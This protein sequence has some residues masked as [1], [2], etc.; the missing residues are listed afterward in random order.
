MRAGFTAGS[1]RARAATVLAALA[2]A[3]AAA[4]S[5][6]MRYHGYAPSDADLAAIRIGTDTRQTVAERLGRPSMVGVLEGSDWFWVQSDWRHE[7]WRAPVETD[8]QVVAISFDNR[9]RV[10]N[11]QR[12]GLRDGEV[13]ALS[14]RVTDAGSRPRVLTQVF[15]VFG[16][17]SPAMAGMAN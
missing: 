13:V 2:L 15:R 12:F 1:I 17:F 14:A 6:Q 3:L 11:I 4:C 8:R 9:D 7:H 16:Q 5:P 10:T